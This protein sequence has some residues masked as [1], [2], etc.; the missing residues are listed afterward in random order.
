MGKGE[1]D[2]CWV[3]L[4]I[5]GRGNGEKRIWKVWLVQLGDYVSSLG[6]GESGEVVDRCSD[7]SDLN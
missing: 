1:W 2:M 6:R 7:R 3:G 5:L 4:R